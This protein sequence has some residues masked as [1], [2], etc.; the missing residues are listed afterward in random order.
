M[1]IIIR[2]EPCHLT[3]KRIQ[4]LVDFF[5]RRIESRLKN[6][7]ASFDRVWTRSTP[8][9]WITDQPTGAMTR[10]VKLWNHTNATLAGVRDDFSYLILRVVVAIG[11][12]LMKLRKLLAFD[13]KPLVLGQMPMKHIEL[14][15]AI[16]SRLRLR[17]SIVWKCRATSIISPRQGKR[18]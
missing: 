3:Q 18:G 5:A 11:T 12:Q 14:H 1:Q 10:Y 17:T 7:R 15:A 13:P 6:S 16:A 9:F 4:K 2:E 8:K